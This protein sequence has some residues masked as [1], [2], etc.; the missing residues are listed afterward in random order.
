M[1]SGSDG[2]TMRAASDLLDEFEV[3][4]GRRI[5]SAQR[6]P[7]WMYTSAR[8]A[9]QPGLRLIIASAGANG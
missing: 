4:N 5:V 1:G 2:E 8:E 6:V 7:E 9:K 3:P